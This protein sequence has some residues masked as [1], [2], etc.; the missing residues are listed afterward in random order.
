MSI[1]IPYTSSRGNAFKQLFQ[2]IPAL[3]PF[4]T[5]AEANYDVLPIQTFVHDHWEVPVICV[6]VYLAGIFFGTKFMDKVEYKNIWDTRMVLAGWNALLCTFSF[7]G[8]LRTVPHLLYN[9]T[10]QSF[11]TTICT[12]PDVEW[13]LGSTG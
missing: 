9:L 12:P 6:V 13:G 7:M 11:E 10:S 5:K 8:A 1:D 2:N 4:Y 3:T